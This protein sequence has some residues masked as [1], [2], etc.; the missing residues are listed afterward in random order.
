MVYNNCLTLRVQTLHKVQ[1][2]SKGNN[3]LSV[4][5]FRGWRIYLEEISA[6]VHSED[7]TVQIWTEEFH[8]NQNNLVRAL[9]VTP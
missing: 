7:D 1:T 3:W 2:C 8:V 9:K 6:R 5:L 4:P